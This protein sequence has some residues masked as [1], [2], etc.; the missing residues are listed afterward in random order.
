VSE[1]RFTDYGRAQHANVTLDQLRECGLSGGVIARMVRDGRL[2]RTQPR[3]YRIGGVPPT[4][5]SE[6]F[7]AAAA[8]GLAS[9]RSA[10]RLWGLGEDD[11]SIDITVP[12]NRRPRLRGVVLHRQSL[13]PRAVRRHGIMTTTPM[14]AMV[15]LGA[16][17]TP[18]VVADAVEVGL[19]SGLFTVTGLRRELEAVSAYGR[20][21][22]GVLR[23]VL[24]TRD[25]GERP[26][27]SVLEARM[28]KLY[29]RF[30]LPVPVFQFEVWAG[31]VFIA[32]LDFA[33][34]DIKLAIEVDGWSSRATSS[35][36]RRS[37]ERQNALIANGWAILRLTWF[38]IVTNPAKVA[39]DIAREVLRLRSMRWR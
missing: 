13:M 17:A 22:A 14:R 28:A 25:L 33:Y 29:R 9:H 24:D 2:E 11:A 38:D 15:D 23:R 32:R 20:N 30:G 8:G 26:A 19:I 1:P 6:V 37:N 3:I 27:E 5:E 34:P 36:L 21:G 10:A 16:V 7:A 18:Q 35:D 4:W 12:V 39:A 31:G